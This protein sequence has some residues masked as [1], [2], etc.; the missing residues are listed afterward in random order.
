MFSQDES[1]R[2]MFRHNS[3]KKVELLHTYFVP[4]HSVYAI[5]YKYAGVPNTARYKLCINYLMARKETL[6][7][8]HIFVFN[9]K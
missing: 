3:N 8:L 9:N 2:A 1:K 6:Y 5:H 7:T 4:N